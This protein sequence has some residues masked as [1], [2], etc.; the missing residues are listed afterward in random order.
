MNGFDFLCL[1]AYK[2]ELPNGFFVDAVGDVGFLKLFVYGKKKPLDIMSLVRVAGVKKS[3]KNS[4]LVVKEI[5]VIDRFE[6]I[7][8]SFNYL[9]TALLVI[10]IVKKTEAKLPLVLETFRNTEI[11]GCHIALFI[12][13]AK[14]LK[15]N[16]VF[17]RKLYDNNDIEVIKKVLKAENCTELS[18][19]DR[20]QSVFKK[21]L[22]SVEKYTNINITKKDIVRR[23]LN[24]GCFPK[25]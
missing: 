9:S 4:Y 8:V 19:F 15:E 5:D 3:Q 12:F 25:G 16:G 2:Y 18:C 10:E 1:I 20:F 11:K 24:E 7:R 22:L 13:C 23:L 14:F 21:L 6:Q 17:D